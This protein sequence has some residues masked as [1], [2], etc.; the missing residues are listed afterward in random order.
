MKN[1]SDTI[2]NQTRNLPACRAV[3]RPTAPL[4]APNESEEHLLK[5]HTLREP[6]LAQLGKVLHKLFTAMNSKGK[7]MTGPTINE[8][9]KSFDDEMEI[10]DKCA[11]CKGSNKKFLVSIARTCV[12]TVT[13]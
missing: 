2:R 3:P 13:A 8:K 11:F 12:S 7:P 4:C 10:N 5:Q 6:K 9:A 1:S